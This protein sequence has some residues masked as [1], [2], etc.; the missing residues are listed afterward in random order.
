MWD[1]LLTPI[2]SRGCTGIEAGRLGT[3]FAGTAWSWVAAINWNSPAVDVRRQTRSRAVPSIASP[4]T[5][6]DVSVQGLPL[7]GSG[8]TKYEGAAESVE[9]CRLVQAPH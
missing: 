9:T 2:T 6:Q 3:A 7:A 8:G 1:P 4:C 5:L